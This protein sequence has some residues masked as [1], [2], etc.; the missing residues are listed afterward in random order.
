MSQNVTLW[1]KFRRRSISKGN[2]IALDKT[3]AT[4]SLRAGAGK[5]VKSDT[6][7]FSTNIRIPAILEWRRD[8]RLGPLEE[9]EV[10]VVRIDLGTGKECDDEAR[11][12]TRLPQWKVLSEA[13]QGRGLRFVRHRDRRRFVVCRGTVRMVL[14]QLLGIPADDVVFRSGSGGKP[15]L[16]PVEHGR[17]PKSGKS[18]PRFNVTHSG[19]FALLALCRD[20][21]LGVDLEHRR[22]IAE[23]SRIVASY[24]TPA[25]CSQFLGLSESIR[26]VAF[27]RGWT[28]KEAILKA[29]GVGLAGLAT[30]FE[31]MFGTAELGRNFTPTTPLHQVQGWSLWEAAPCEE[32]VAALAV[33]SSPT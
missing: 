9:S 17:G 3:F 7:S 20:R 1:P 2:S 6:M 8:I 31:T 23:S 5:A 10:R 12:L 24:F 15:E 19:D 22:T 4:W 27:L 25:E 33:Q 30:S 18:L 11:D 32:Y 16:D 28:R 13:E 26:D 21:E 29:R 14:G